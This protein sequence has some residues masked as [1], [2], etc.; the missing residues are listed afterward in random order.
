[1][2]EEWRHGERVIAQVQRSNNGAMRVYIAFFFVEKRIIRPILIWPEKRKQPRQLLEN[3][4]RT[5]NNKGHKLFQYII[6]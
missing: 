6:H 1:M 4:G 3:G 5:A 2:I